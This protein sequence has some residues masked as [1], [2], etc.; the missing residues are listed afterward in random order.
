V[1]PFFPKEMGPRRCHPW[2]WWVGTGGAPYANL[3]RQS[4]KNANYTFGTGALRWSNKGLE[5]PL[6]FLGQTAG[7]GDFLAPALKS[8][9]CSVMAS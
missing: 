7:D 9:R 3:V 1:Q 2:P 8:Y 6:L 4:V 5:G